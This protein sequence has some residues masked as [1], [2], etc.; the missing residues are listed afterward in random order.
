MC[1]EKVVVGGGG[2]GRGGEAVVT[3]GSEATGC[4]V[5]PLIVLLGP[6]VKLD[7]ELVLTC[8]YHL[9]MPHKTA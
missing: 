7:V 8:P 2:G 3:Y 1:A 6:A 4:G 5:D 9:T